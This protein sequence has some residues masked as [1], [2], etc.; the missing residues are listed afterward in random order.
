MISQRLDLRQT[1]TLVMTPLLQQAIKLLQ[2]SHQELTAYV[3]AEIENNPL[4]EKPDAP[5]SPEILSSRVDTEPVSPA[6]K[7]AEGSGSDTS[8]TT[9]TAESD[10]REGWDNDTPD[11]PYAERHETRVANGFDDAFSA[12]ANVAAPQTLRD[13]LLEQIHVDFPDPTDRLAAVSFIELLDEAGYLPAS[14]DQACAQLGLDKD[15]LDSLLARLHRLDPPGIFARSL[16]ECLAIQLRERNRLDPAMATLLDH[17]D[18][19]AKRATDAL[20][21]L[22]GVDAED[23]QDMIAELRRLTPKPALAFGGE[24]PPPITPDVFLHPL[25]GGGWQ[26]EL[27]GDN[28]PRVLANEAY[29]ARIQNGAR[30]KDD[31]SYI[32]ERWQKANWLIKALHQRA[33]TILKVASEIVRRQ[34]AFFVH[35]IQFL[36]PLTLRDIATAI[37]MHESTVSRVTQ[38]KYLATPRGLFE[39]KYFF[40]NALATTGGEETVSTLAVRT[41]IKELIDAE[42]PDAIL[43]DDR[44][45]ALLRQE[46]ID[47]ARRTVAKYREALRLPSSAQRKREKASR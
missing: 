9:A 11:D 38:N 36:K 2:M 39:L 28:L 47:I 27:N 19:V 21:K 17:L 41:R 44:L 22:C 15:R 26:I 32:T 24:L 25:P 29:F 4:L 34:D 23:L 42:K 13:H 10:P 14:L 7:G 37:E 6:P 40:T 35:G 16:Q 18:L 5:A 20:M 30:S 1:Q 31:K 8:R 46:G 43:S 45:A 33:T 12:V 3:A